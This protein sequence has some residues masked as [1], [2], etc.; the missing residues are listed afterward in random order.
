MKYA[1]ILE[2]MM[3]ICFGLSWPTSIIKSIRS[4]STKGKSLLFMILIDA[5][6][7]FGIAGKIL[8]GNVTYVCIFYVLNF[9]MVLADILIYFKNRAG[10]K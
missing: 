5:G 9:F 4:R 6:Y 1:E 8:S 3:V 7:V 10:E 2:A